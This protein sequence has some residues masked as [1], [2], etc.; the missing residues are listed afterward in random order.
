MP[1]ELDGKIIRTRKEHQCFACHKIFTAG[2]KMLC[3]SHANDKPYSLY[4]CLNCQIIMNEFDGEM[5]ND[6]WEYEWGCVKEFLAARGYS[7]D[8]IDEFIKN[9]GL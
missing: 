1:F 8:R 9:E 3:G 6:E 5:V 7:V 4:W 2:T